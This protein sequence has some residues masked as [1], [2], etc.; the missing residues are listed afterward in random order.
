MKTTRRGLFRRLVA[1]PIAAAIGG[2]GKPR[3]KPRYRSVVSIPEPLD[4]SGVDPGELA[5]EMAL[6]ARATDRM[7]IIRTPWNADDLFAE[8]RE[9]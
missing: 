5:E 3:R 2:G 8:F 1:A 4:L 6:E 9:T 7:S